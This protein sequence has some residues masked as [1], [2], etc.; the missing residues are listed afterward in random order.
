MRGLFVLCIAGIG[1]AVVEEVFTCARNAADLEELLG[2]CREA[3]W[4][5]VQGIVA[6]VSLPNDRQRVMEGAAAAFGGKLNVLFNN[7]GTFI[8]PTTVDVTQA[9]FQHLINSNLE[10]A[11]ALS[12]LA[13]P[14]LKASGDGVIIFNSSVA[15]GPTA[16]NTGSVYGLTKAALNQ[17]AKSLTCEWGKDN[18]RAVSLAPWFTQTPMVQS[19]LQDVEYAARVLECTPIGRIAQPQEVARVVSF[20]A[21]PAASYMAGCTIPVD[22]GYS[23]RGFY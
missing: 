13:H 14:L 18:I 23:C 21:S 10:S 20:L 9:E 1:K 2:Q 3:G 15:G 4:D 8:T 6:D 7:V 17:L 12:Q 11:F 19:L 5:D 16:M 22:G